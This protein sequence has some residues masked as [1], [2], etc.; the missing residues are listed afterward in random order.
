M[1]ACEASDVTLA[2]EENSAVMTMLQALMTQVKEQAVI[3]DQQ[4]TT[5]LGQL[6]VKMDKQV[7]QM[8]NLAPGFA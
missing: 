1:S 8:K 2:G 3:I 6:A 4:T 7:A 5:I